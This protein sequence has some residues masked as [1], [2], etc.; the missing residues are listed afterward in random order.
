MTAPR[1]PDDRALDAVRRVRDS[2]EQ[3]SRFGLQHALG[4]V[5]D[6]DREVALVS[7]QRAATPTFDA[8]S[9]AQFGAHVDRLSRLA[10]LEQQAVAAA[11]DSRLVADEARNRWQRDRQQVR[12]VDGLLE[13]RA[14]ARAE[15][16]ARREARELDD[17]AAQAWLRERTSR[18]ASHPTS[19]Q[20]SKRTEGVHQ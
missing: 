1:H 17:L 3:D 6:R 13:R 16:R 5:R 15:E 20:T 9:P 19:H 11:R 12:V 18:Q 8:G 7:E 14:L 4:I 10:A 2:R